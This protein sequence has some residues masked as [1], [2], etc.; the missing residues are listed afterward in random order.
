M[1][2]MDSSDCQLRRTAV[3]SLPLDGL[4]AGPVCTAMIT[5]SSVSCASDTAFATR[6]MLAEGP[7]AAID[8]R[9]A[10]VS[11]DQTPAPQCAS[12]RRTF[13]DLLPFAALVNS[14]PTTAIPGTPEILGK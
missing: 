3:E 10:R 5:Q 11:S 8:G 13:G 6:R 2:R 1:F 9:L 14:A 12:E 7:D 4:P